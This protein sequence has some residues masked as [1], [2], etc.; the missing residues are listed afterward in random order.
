MTRTFEGDGTLEA[1]ETP[2]RKFSVHYSIAV[3]DE[4]EDAIPTVAGY[5]T[6]LSESTL[7][8]FYDQGLMATLR[9]DDECYL[10]LQLQADGEIIPGKTNILT[11]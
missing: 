4:G 10:N 1:N 9:M 11:R 2:D 3:H 8:D 7:W 6:G 5:V